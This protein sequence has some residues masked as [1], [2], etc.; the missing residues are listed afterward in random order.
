MT[1]YIS[2]FYQWWL[3]LPDVVWVGLIIV[4]LVLGVIG[5]VNSRRDEDERS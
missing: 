1:H 4:A 5:V 3:N 2:H